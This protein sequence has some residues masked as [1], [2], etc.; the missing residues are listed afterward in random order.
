MKRSWVKKAKNATP[1]RGVAL[2]HKVCMIQRQKAGRK[3]SYNGAGYG[4]RR[5]L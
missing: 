2:S 1:L 3:L 5:Q 4:R